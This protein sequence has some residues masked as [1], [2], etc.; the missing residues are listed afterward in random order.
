GVR[1]LTVEPEHNSAWSAGLLK[2][3]GNRESG[4]F[5]TTRAEYLNGR[6]TS[7]HRFRPQA[8]MYE[9]FT[10]TQGH[11]N[12]G[13]VLG[14]P[15]L[16]R[17]GGFEFAVDRWSSGGRIGGMVQQRSMPLTGEESVPANGARS[18]WALEFNGTLFSRLSEYG[19]R[20]GL[21][22]DLNRTP[23]DDVKNFFVGGSVKL[24]R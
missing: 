22:W 21:A 20:A 12:R 5:W 1:D 6:I 8:T 23:G 14:S 18:Q 13:Q 17:T 2:V 9:H 3:S 15:L 7:L 19:W 10:I 16:E 4:K 24:G 11:T